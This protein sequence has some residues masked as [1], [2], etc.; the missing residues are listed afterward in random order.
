MLQSTI[1]IRVRYAETDQMGIAYHGNYFTWF[2]ACRIQLLDDLRLPYIELEA[3]GWLLP[4]LSC[5]ARF[6]TPA[7][8]DDHLTVR[9]SL[10]ESVRVRITIDYRVERAESLIAEGSTLHAFVNRDGHPVKPPAAFM[11]ALRK[12]G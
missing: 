2:E 5:S 8:F 11:Q 10:S 4:V 7:R 12:K 9:C 1:Q 6:I 3:Q